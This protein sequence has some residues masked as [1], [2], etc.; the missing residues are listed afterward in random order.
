MWWWRRARP[1][2]QEAFARI[3]LIP[4]AGGTWILPRLVGPKLA[5]ALMLT[6][7][8]IPAE[9]AQRLGLV[10]KVFE[11][12]SFADD[13][14]S[15]AARIA[16]GPALAHRLTKEAVAQSLS[17]GLEAQLGLEATLQREAGFSDDFVEGIAA[18][19]EKRAP[20]FK[21]R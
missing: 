8:P 16:A 6:A 20:R 21:G 11:D 3:A 12:S 2:L 7:D 15:L 18:F 14:A 1:Y 10:Y 4:D 17:N 5:L 19:R 13:V 9:E